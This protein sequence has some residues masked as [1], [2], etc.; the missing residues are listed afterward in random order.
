MVDSLV[1][2]KGSAYRKLPN[3]HSMEFF[4]GWYKKTYPG[5]KVKAALFNKV[6]S[7][8]NLCIREKMA[9]EGY[10]FP[11]YGFG[12]IGVYKKKHKIKKLDNGKFNLPVNWPKTYELWNSN[13]KAKA[14]KKFVYN[15]NEH[16]DGYKVR[17]MWVRKRCTSRVTAAHLYTFATVL[18]FRRAVYL[19][20]MNNNA[21]ENYYEV[22]K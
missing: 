10:E 7:D 1:N 12:V 17:I 18:R 20:I 6:V 19:A 21:I 22:P 15:L 13:P 14:E 8:F 4:Y 2:S 9:N 5:T 3:Y 11:I 16:T